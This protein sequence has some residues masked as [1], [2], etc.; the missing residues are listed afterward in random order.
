M[1]Y[2]QVLSRLEGFLPLERAYRL[3]LFNIIFLLLSS[4]P[5]SAQV[6][7][8]SNPPVD[9]VEESIPSF[10]LVSPAFPGDQLATDDF[11]AHEELLGE[12]TDNT[13][14]GVTLKE[15]DSDLVGELMKQWSVNNSKD[16]STKDYANE[17]TLF[18]GAIDAKAKSALIYSAANQVGM[19]PQVL[20]G[21]LIE[22]SSM[23]DM[24]ISID[25]GNWSCGIGQT[26][27]N[28]WCLW[29]NHAPADLQAK[30]N[31]PTAE[32][33][34]FYAQNPGIAE[35]SDYT[36]DNWICSGYFLRAAH[37]KP[38]FD[39]G[40]E[41]F[42]EKDSLAQEYELSSKWIPEV[43]FEDA[44]ATLDSVTN[45]E[46]NCPSENKQDDECLKVQKTRDEGAAANLRY[47]MAKSF[48]MNCDHH[49]FQIPAKAYILKSIYDHLGE[50]DKKN[51][52]FADQLKQAQQY[53]AGSSYG[54]KCNTK[55]T[56]NSYP[57]SVSWL[58]ADVVYNAGD[59]IEE[60]I[61]Q[62][63]KNNHWSA[64]TIS[65]QQLVDSIDYSLAQRKSQKHMTEIGQCEARF[66]LRDVLCDLT[67]PG[68]K[69]MAD[70]ADAT[71]KMVPACPP[72]GEDCDTLVNKGSSEDEFPSYGRVKVTK[73]KKPKAPKTPKEARN[74]K[75]Q[76]QPVTPV[77]DN[78]SDSSA[79]NN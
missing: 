45:H 65:P 72:Q 41:K 78:T 27:A 31:W 64:E 28:E 4:H 42:K 73:V 32:I 5:A 47:L 62:Y 10:P 76:P 15:T 26:N 51:P 18:E 40:M 20:A 13:P 46:M 63:W 36:A 2:Y 7:D 74:K 38:F 1:R 68:Q 30:I 12:I 23:V 58:L 48:A 8:L 22:E 39:K 55:V 61:F 33:A 16:E 59:A 77:T 79:E 24:G 11:G 17:W 56:T 60:D 9:C 19:P 6:A 25:Y 35:R 52:Q 75:N 70:V 71:G 66:H 29:A 67:L 21:S 69:I 50:D 44:Q 49:E 53:P 37:A 57:L 3:S 54:R 43:S 14:P 34:A